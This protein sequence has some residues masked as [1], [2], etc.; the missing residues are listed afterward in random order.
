MVPTGLEDRRSRRG[1]DDDGNRVAKAA[2]SP[3]PPL[4]LR[5]RAVRTWW[6]GLSCGVCFAAGAWAREG[7]GLFGVVLALA[8]VCGEAMLYSSLG[9]P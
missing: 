2:P 6:R 7:H 1:G 9:I 5:D 3:P 4:L 8:A